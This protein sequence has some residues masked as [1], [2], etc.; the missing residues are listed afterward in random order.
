MSIKMLIFNN[1]YIFRNKP[2]SLLLFVLMKW[3]SVIGRMDSYGI[4]HCPRWHSD[5]ES[6][7][8]CRRCRRGEFDPWVGTIPWGR[9]GNPLQFG[10]FHTQR[11]LEGYS[12]WGSKKSDITERLNA[13]TETHTSH[14]LLTITGI[15]NIIKVKK[16]GFFYVTSEKNGIS[17]F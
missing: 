14:C 3:F 17:F 8:H 16:M 4:Y 11:N 10:N 9:N 5:K 2:L 13:Y 6:D 1:Q 12:P 15:I 7:S